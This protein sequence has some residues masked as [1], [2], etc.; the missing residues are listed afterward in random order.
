MKI[1]KL[2]IIKNIGSFREFRWN[3]FCSHKKK[4]DSLED[5]EIWKKNIFFGDNGN[6][7]S[8]I[9]K[10]L[11]SLNEWT[12]IL[13]KNWDMM[14]KE[15]EIK[16]TIDWG[17]SIEF[18]ST[19]W[20]SSDFK[21]KI[22]IFDKDFIRD[23]VGD[24]HDET[25]N[26][27]SK[28]RW[29]HFFTL[30]EFTEKERKLADLTQ[31]RIKINNL[32]VSKDI[33]DMYASFENYSNDLDRG[34][35]KIEL[36]NNLKIEQEKNKNLIIR[37]SNLL[38]IKTINFPSISF[39]DE[40]KF[41]SD[42]GV[43]SE[44]LSSIEFEFW[45]ESAIKEIILSIHKNSCEKCLVCEQSI[46]SG[47]VYMARISTLV[48]H[49]TTQGI[50]DKEKNMNE[51]LENI[52][53]SLERIKNFKNEL[54]N[55]SRTYQ[56]KIELLK[57]YGDTSSYIYT[58]SVEFS[59]SEEEVQ[60]IDDILNKISEKQKAKS[61]IVTS[62]LTTISKIL[63]TFQN[64][65]GELG[66][67]TTENN[68]FLEWVKSQNISSIETDIK[69][70]EEKIA[71]CN[72]WITF[73]DNYVRIS[74]FIS[75]CK[76]FYIEETVGEIDWKFKTALS[77]LRTIISD[78]FNA[79]TEEYGALIKDNITDINSSISVDF[80]C[81]L[82]GG[83][84]HGSARC[85][86]RISYNWESI[87][88][89]LSDG[90]KRVVGLSYFFALTQKRCDKS[91]MLVFDDPVTDF[92]AWHKQ[93]IASKISEFAKDYEQTIV[94]THDEKFF[95]YI[96]KQNFD[97]RFSIQ[98]VHK[99]SIIACIWKEQRELYE[100]D[101]EDFYLNG[102]SSDEYFRIRE[103]IYKLRYCMESQIKNDWLLHNEERFDRI[104]D[105]L[106]K[107]P[108]WTKEQVK[109]LKEMYSFCNM[110]GSHEWS[111]EWYNGLKKNFEWYCNLWYCI[112]PSIP[113]EESS[114]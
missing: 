39:F 98:K 42:F 102:L 62:D 111:C 63:E 31:E 45:W 23:N 72:L 84:S 73:I 41:C 14:G 78:K 1:K 114:P 30:G 49:F 19:G 92:D 17:G 76:S 77:D 97:F 67:Y 61:S 9:V 70:T 74:E 95:E 2:S 86:F 18:P 3:S 71:K 33:M 112:L 32:L 15:Q 37:K 26:D 35:K 93:I 47:N 38:Q 29:A 53:K 54:L 10:V 21:W 91:W 60:L 94:F 85:G 25:E 96:S 107:M 87:A 52:N 110:N 103:L 109:I 68:K 56:E 5:A 105:K 81:E 11:K 101:L 44:K 34:V 13:P 12:N 50:E 65:L 43:F 89:D 83:I 113:P 58:S 6:W 75:S 22:H 100:K 28:K 79:F 55:F 90:E 46:K 59:L 106:E 80:D 20:S 57:S 99:W 8:T 104:L 7:K 66:K 36:E 64:T 48:Q 27:T 88:R 108:K 24:L 51:K 16:I 82:N 69:A 4:D 40:K